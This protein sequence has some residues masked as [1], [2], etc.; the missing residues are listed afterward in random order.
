MLSRCSGEPGI[1]SRRTVIAPVEFG[2]GLLHAVV[3]EF[4]ATDSLSI[5]KG[6]ELRQLGRLD[7]NFRL[8]C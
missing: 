5:A 1:D 3:A 6:E 2:Y 7:T 8:F 4:F